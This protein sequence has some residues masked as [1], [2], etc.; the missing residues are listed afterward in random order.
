MADSELE[1]GSGRF[2][3]FAAEQPEGIGLEIQASIA[4]SLKRI[5]DFVTT[6]PV[7][8]KGEPPSVEALE[9]LR[10]HMQ[11]APKGVFIVPPI[12]IDRT[13]VLEKR[14]LRIAQ[15]IEAVDNRCAAADGPVTPTLKEMTQAEISHIYDLAK[16]KT[17]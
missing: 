11:G 1:P 16:G 4:I 13:P 10:E 12:E 9:Q 17:S 7:M 15:I 14:L 8:Y 5:A 3:S 2:A 6:P